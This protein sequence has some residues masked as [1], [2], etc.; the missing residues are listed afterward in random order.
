MFTSKHGSIVE[1]SLTL[2]KQQH[3]WKLLDVKQTTELLET[4]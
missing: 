2:S 1:N 3:C 4:A